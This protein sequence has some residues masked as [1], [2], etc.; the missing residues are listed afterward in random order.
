[1]ANGLYSTPLIK[2]LL[3]FMG[4]KI[5]LKVNPHCPEQQITDDPDDDPAPEMN[6]MGKG[7]H[8]LIGSLRISKNILKTY[9]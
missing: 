8:R 3:K 7:Q 5:P 6:R 4:I 2:P 9:V 1:M